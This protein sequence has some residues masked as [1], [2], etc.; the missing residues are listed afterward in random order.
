MYLKISQKGGFI[1]FLDPEGSGN[2][3]KKVNTPQ[4]RV[5]TFFEG[6]FWVPSVEIFK[7]SQIEN[8]I[9]FQKFHKVS[10]TFIGF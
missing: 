1:P 8:F 7:N 10:E 2:P 9:D 6:G 5:F 4:K 3:L